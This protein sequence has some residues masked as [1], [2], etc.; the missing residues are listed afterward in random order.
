MTLQGSPHH[1]EAPQARRRSDWGQEE[2]RCCLQEGLYLFQYFENSKLSSLLTSKVQKEKRRVIFKSAQRYAKEYRT[3][4]RNLVQC[5]RAAR[6]AGNYFVEPE[7]KVA[8][9]VRIRGIN[10]VDPRTKKILQLFR[11]R[12]VSG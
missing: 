5:R 10:G 4:A 3:A 1:P 8:I 12:Q 7:A 11:L 9:V 2:D 6:A